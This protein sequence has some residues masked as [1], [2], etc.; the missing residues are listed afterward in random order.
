MSFLDLDGQSQQNLVERARLNPLDLSAG[1]TGIFDGA[2]TAPFKGLAKGLLVEPGRALNLALSAIPRAIDAV[3]GGTE[4]QDWWFEKTVSDKS[5]IGRSAKELMPDAHTTG[6]VGQVLHSFFDIG[7][8]ALTVG[9]FGTAVFKGTGKATELVDKGV[10]AGT[11]LKAGGVEGASIGVGVHLPLSIGLKSFGNAFYG[12]AASVI[13]NAASRGAVHTIL[14]EAGH[15]DIADQ[16][17]WLDAQQIAIDAILGVGLGFLGTRLEAR[18]STS[19]REALRPSDVDTALAAHNARHVEVDTA[20][21]LPT[22][23]AAREAHVAALTKATDD[24][25]A[26]R[27]VDV[28]ETRVTDAAFMPNPRRAELAEQVKPLLK[29]HDEAVAAVREQAA[30]FEAAPRPEPEPQAPAPLEGPDP[31]AMDPTPAA[32]RTIEDPALQSEL[33]RMAENESGW[34][35]VGGRLIRVKNSEVAGDET[36]ARTKWIPKADWWPGR[37]DKM[38]PAQTQ[39]AVR[40][41]LAGEQLSAKEGRMV[42]YLTDVANERLA[43]VRS[44]GEE[45]FLAITEDVRAEGLEPTHANAIDADLVARAARLDEEQ[46]ETAAIKFEND[47]AAFMAEIRRILNDQETEPGQAA[48]PGAAAARGGEAHRPAAQQ[49]A[50]GLE[51]TSPT[52]AD[53]RA[54]EQQARAGDVEQRTAAV[55]DRN[56]A[57]LTAPEGT[58]PARE[59]AQTP[60]QQAGLFGREQ[61]EAPEVGQAQQLIAERPDLEIRLVDG[62]TMK[63][64]EAAKLMDE[65]LA[66]AKTEASAFDAAVTCFLRG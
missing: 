21:G 31:W 40:K 29:E 7:A 62:S 19:L 46:V 38:N 27:P 11:A 14:A 39:E 28:T 34:A 23:P 26:G 54:Q 50:Q 13:P 59:L 5:G 1:D 33:T 30:E 15:H 25:I 22:T 47:D 12:A 16:Y 6:I 37:P 8:Q 66:T 53:L 32:P 51:L 17:R 55:R 20:P 43:A 4:A 36:I 2:V 64:A 10:D 3:R 24:L 60:T 56:S 65:V 58:A 49:Q 18:A 42:A 44:L 45:E 9:P 63:A 35:E 48:Q 57:I 52:E 41:A 61:A